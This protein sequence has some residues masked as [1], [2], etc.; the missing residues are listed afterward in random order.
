VAVNVRLYFDVQIDSEDP[1]V[2]QRVARQELEQVA[3]EEQIRIKNLRFPNVYPVDT[4]HAMRAD[5]FQVC[6]ICM[7]KDANAETRFAL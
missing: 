7:A 1:A 4:W 5:E 6:Q 3:D 2:I